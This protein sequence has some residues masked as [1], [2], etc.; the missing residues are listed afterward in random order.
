MRNKHFMKITINVLPLPLQIGDLH[1]E[2]TKK[3]SANKK[4]VKKNR[5]HLNILY[6]IYKNSISN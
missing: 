5:E 1:F 3:N 6:L 2:N 4:K